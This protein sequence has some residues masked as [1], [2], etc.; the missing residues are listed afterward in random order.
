MKSIRLPICRARPLLALLVA[1]LSLF[2]PMAGKG[3]ERQVLRGHVPAATANLAPTGR[4]DRNKHLRLSIGLPPRDPAALAQ[5]LA[6]LYDPASPNYRKFLTPAQ[7]TEKFSPTAADYQAVSAFAKTHHLTVT[8]HPNRLMVSL[9]GVT[10]DI[11]DA[12]HVRLQTYRH[13]Q[14]AREFYAPDAEPS[15][16]L[17]TPVL[18]VSGLD[19]YYLPHSNLRPKPAG[20]AGNVVPNDGPTGSAPNGAYSPADLRAAYVPGAALTGA[21]QSVGLLQ[22]DGFY[23]SDV[24]A[25]RTQFG[26]PNTPTVVVPVDGGI[27]IVG[28]DNA[29]VALDIEMASAM[30]PGLSTIYVYELNGPWDDV[31]SRMASDN[32]AKQLSCSWTGGPPDPTAE[33]IFQEMAAQGQSFFCSSG[34]NNATTGAFSFPEDSPNITLVG[35]TTLT[36]SG[37]GGTYVSE[38][39]WNW[40]GGTGSAGGIST[41]FGIPSWQNGVSMA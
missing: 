14:E 3:A 20:R 24:A 4:L 31:L 25:Y 7:F 36:T 39:V 10:A 28:A 34:D 6:D 9:E 27:E 11:E 16:D 17:A 41:V 40:G 19:D 15:L 32:L 2:W 38:T 29:E 26:L 35:G 1:G 37:P 5:F 22:F 30:A 23:P 12:F 13:P 33:V 21:G 8:A 18:H